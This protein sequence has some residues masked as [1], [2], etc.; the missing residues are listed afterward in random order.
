VSKRDTTF[1]KRQRELELE[2]K[3]RPRKREQRRAD[4][5]LRPKD[6]LANAGVDP[7]IAGIVAGPQPENE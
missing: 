6:G 2:Q 7:D 5:R 4:R 3:E 1:A